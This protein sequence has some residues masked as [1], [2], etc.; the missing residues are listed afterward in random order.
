MVTAP[1]LFLFR[2]NANLTRDSHGAPLISPLFVAEQ[3]PALQIVDVRPSD[4]AIG[5]LGYV[6]GSSFPGIEQLKQLERDAGSAP[7]VLVSASG[8]TS[9]KVAR[10]LADLGHKNVAAMKG[11]LAA[12]R[13]LGL[14]TSRDPAGVRDALYDVA[15]TD[16]ESG[17]L[18]VEH[19]RAHIGDPR[20]VRWIKLPSL[21]AQGRLSCIDGRDERGVIGSPGGDGGE[22]LLTLA[23]IEQATG[24]KLDEE[25]VTFGLLSHLD[26]FGSFYM[27]TDVH[28]FEALVGALQTDPDVQSAAA[29]VTRPEEWFEFVQNAPHELQERL[30]EHTW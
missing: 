4:D 7:M 1:S 30:L 11:G 2:W 27:H 5:V 25:A 14:A 22:F 18:T 21:I 26:T 15:E 3:G 29:G 8:N 23:A 12:W 9:A 13:A 6:P 24:R 17:P 10:Q 19:V 28:A 16:I 20:S